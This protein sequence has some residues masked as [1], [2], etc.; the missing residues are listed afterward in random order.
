MATTKKEVSVSD[1]E[2]TVAA[3]ENTAATPE[4]ER[5][6]GIRNFVYVG[7]SLP[8]GKLK[9]NTILS[10]SYAEITAYYGEA[11]TLYPG[12]EK[13]IVPVTRLAEAREKVKNGGNALHEHFQAIT[14]AVKAK[15]EV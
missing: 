6:A 8:G 5:Y 1:T 13:L 10:G 7:P 4:K 14:A 3:T 11:I 2:N 9:N 15:G 12:V